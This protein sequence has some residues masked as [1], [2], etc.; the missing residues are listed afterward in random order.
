MSTIYFDKV[1]KIM[2]VGKKKGV[3]LY[4]PRIEGRG[5]QSSKQLAKR[6]QRASTLSTSDINAIDRSFS[7]YV[8]E[9]LLE[10]HIVDLGALGNIRPKFDA[11]AVDTLEECDASSIRDMSV[12][13]RGSAELKEALDNIKFEYRPGY[14]STS[15]I[16]EEGT[17]PDS[18][19]EV[20]DDDNTDTGGTTPGGNTGDGGF[21][22]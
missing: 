17:T 9:Y 4:G 5:T 8:I 13:F 21:E 15:I 18:G 11:K 16:D 12:E 14:T 1:T 6:I 2:K 10:G 3:T 20:P 7:E 19:D 22:G